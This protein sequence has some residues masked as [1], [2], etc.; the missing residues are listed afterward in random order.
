VEAIVSL[1]ELP[2]NQ[3]ML[4]EFCFQT[5]HIPIRDFATPSLGQIEDFVAFAKEAIDCGKKIV[6]HCDAGIGRTATMLACYLVSKGYSAVE[7]IQVVRRKRPGSIE[8][9]EQEKVVNEYADVCGGNI[10][11]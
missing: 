7:A 11:N 3:K 8:T 10:N 1:S 2:L 9:V 6:V 4:H 5:I